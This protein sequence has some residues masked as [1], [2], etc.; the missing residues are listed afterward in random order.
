MKLKSERWRVENSRNTGSGCAALSRS[1]VSASATPWV[2]AHQAPL[3]GLSRP[4]SWSVLPFP[5]PGDLPHPEIKPESPTLQADSLLSEPPGKSSILEWVAVSFFKRLF[6]T[7]GLKLGFL[8]CS[9]ILYHLS[10]QGRP[11]ILEQVAYPFSRGSS[12]PRK[13]GKKKT[14]EWRGIFTM[15]PKVKFYQKKIFFVNQKMRYIYFLI[16]KCEP[17]VSGF[18]IWWA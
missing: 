18:Q 17:A 10:L 11:R 8:H 4:E 6:P 5:H 7:Q 16:I 15:K 2:V 1:V 13:K 12:R 14:T 3:W 9:Q